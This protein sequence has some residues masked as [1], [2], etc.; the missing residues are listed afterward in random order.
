MSDTGTS[1][2]TCIKTVTI[3]RNHRTLDILGVAS[4][5]SWFKQAPSRFFTCM[6]FDV[7]D[8]TVTCIILYMGVLLKVY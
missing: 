4:R 7:Y 6:T 1:V 2:N 8:S 5:A 3:Y